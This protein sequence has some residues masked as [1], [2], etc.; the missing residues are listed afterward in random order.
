MEDSFS[1]NQDGLVGE[2]W[3]LDD[4]SVLPLLCILFHYYYLVIYNEVI[5]HLTIMQN[6]W[7]P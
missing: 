5:I 7:E 1:I 2:G 6:Q 4:S 3:F